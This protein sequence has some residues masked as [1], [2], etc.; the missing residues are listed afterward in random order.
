MSPTTRRALAHAL[1]ATVIAIACHAAVSAAVVVVSLVTLQRGIVADLPWVRPVQQRLYARVTRHVWQRQ[2]DCV[3][4]DEVLV[5]RPRIGTCSFAN[6]EFATHLTFAASGRDTGPR[7]AGP[8]IAVLGDS[9]A[10][11]WGVE[12]HETFAAELQRRTGRPV[13]N[14]AVSS[15]ATLRELARLARSGLVDSVDTVVLQ[16][17]DNDLAENEWGRLDT[18]ER[19]RGK[20]ERVRFGRATGLQ[21]AGAILGA[22][23]YSAVVPL[24][25]LLDA[26]GLG[27]RHHFAPHHGPLVAALAQHPELRSKRVLVTYV[28][29][30]GRRFEGFPTGR[31]PRLP[32]VEFVEVDAGLDGYFRLDDHMNA[33]GHAAVAAQLQSA[34]GE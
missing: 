2:R 14:L 32:W 22:C 3:D 26:A 11:G 13:Y 6:P 33:A 30:R 25:G 28:N 7:P 24:R 21:A 34:L 23:L 8:G 10:M 20:F 1:G 12:D 19:N 16:Y 18:P 29:G 17:S 31:D 27:Q 4:F 5:Y 15:Y 9:H